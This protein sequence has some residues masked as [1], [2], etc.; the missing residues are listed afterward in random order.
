MRCCVAVCLMWV[1]LSSAVLAGDASELKVAVVDVARVMAAHPSTQAADELLQKQL[2]EF[3]VE[4]KEMLKEGEAL[5]DAYDTAL[6]EASDRALSEAGRA[7]KQKAAAKTRAELRAFEQQYVET[8][9]ERQK[10]LND[11]EN[12]MRRRIIDKVET[13]V[14]EAAED[15]GYTL[16]LDAS[17]RGVAGAKTVLAHAEALDIT[18]AVLKRMAKE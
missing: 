17:S 18:E 5:K 9:R 6:Q 14:Q 11:Q 16:V 12:R 2:R 1:A 13:L 15:G 3:E 10:Q 8:I 4:Q 7:S